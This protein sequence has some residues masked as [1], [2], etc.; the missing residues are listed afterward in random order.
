MQSAISSTKQI[1]NFS[2]FNSVN[3]DFTI[4]GSLIDNGQ[5]IL[6]PPNTG[7]ANTF[8]RT[9]GAGITTWVAPTIALLGDVS[10]TS[11][12]T[13]NLIKFNGASWIN[14][15]LTSSDVGLGTITTTGG[16][17]TITS[18]FTTTNGTIG[19]GAASGSNL[20]TLVDNLA[21]AL[22]VGPVGKNFL[23]L[24]STTGSSSM[25]I[26]Q[27][28]SMDKSLDM[29]LVTSAAASI[30]LDES[31]NIWEFSNVAGAAVTLPQIS[32]RRYTLI[33]SGT[34]SAVIISPNVADK[35]DGT[36]T[37]ITLANQWDRV[38]LVYSSFSA[39]W[40]TV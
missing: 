5:S 38:E 39:T 12:T 10:F 35:I 36:L 29:K 30:T 7:S 18:T 21:S 23:T 37:S 31:A 14:V 16:N 4:G 24:I 3:A 27:R 6:F 40:Y 2:L 9:N 19:F 26:G 11:L 8:L 22:V 25:T 28:T 1:G 17:T 13:G 15:V 20:I 33:K 34:G 32:G